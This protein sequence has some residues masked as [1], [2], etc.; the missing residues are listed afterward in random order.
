MVEPNGLVRAV[1]HNE[2]GEEVPLGNGE[3]F[4]DGPSYKF[5][6]NGGLR[7]LVLSGTN[8]K[9]SMDELFSHIAKGSA[10]PVYNVSMDGTRVSGR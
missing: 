9:W 1:R 6:N 7:N 10:Q 8:S 4:Q 3:C 5:H 2:S